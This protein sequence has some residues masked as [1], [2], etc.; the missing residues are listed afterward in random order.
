MSGPLPIG[1]QEIKRILT[2][3]GVHF[4]SKER[5]PTLWVKLMKATRAERIHDNYTNQSNGRRPLT[6]RQLRRIAKAQHRAR[7]MMK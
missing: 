1:M 4:T 3:R 6:P 5:K 2:E 7:G